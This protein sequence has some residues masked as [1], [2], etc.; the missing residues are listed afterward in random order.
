MDI[1]KEIE[2]LSLLLPQNIPPL[3]MKAPKESQT[4]LLTGAAGFLGSF[5]LAD[6]LNSDAQVIVHC[7]VRSKDQ[8]PHAKLRDIM[9][10]NQL[11]NDAFDN[12]I[13]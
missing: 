10:R 9:K 8:D 11:W 4:I 2:T 5:I 3:E 1:L 7:L 13:R 12:R 6:L